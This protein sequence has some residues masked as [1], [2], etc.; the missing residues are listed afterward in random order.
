MQYML[1]ALGF[2]ILILSETFMYI[3][4]SNDP[5]KYAVTMSI[6]CID[7][8]FCIVSDIKYHKVILLITEG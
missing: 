8:Q 2:G 6:N 1:W 4:E 7:R 3:S 5:Y